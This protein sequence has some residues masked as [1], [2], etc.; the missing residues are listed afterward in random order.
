MRPNN[1]FLFQKSNLV[2][3]HYRWLNVIKPS[4]S[5]FV[6]TSPELELALYTICFLTYA[7]DR[8]PLSLGGKTFG[9]QTYTYRL[10]RNRGT[11]IGSAYPIF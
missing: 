1:S 2:K 10:N 11:V 5:M 9:I 8:C 4:G 6:G 7:D 3:V